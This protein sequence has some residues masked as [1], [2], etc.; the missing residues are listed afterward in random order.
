MKKTW[1]CNVRKPFGKDARA[2]R[3]DCTKEIH[4]NDPKFDEETN[5]I[6]KPKKYD[7]KSRV[8]HAT[9]IPP[10]RF[11]AGRAEGLWVKARAEP[12][13]G[14]KGQAKAKVIQN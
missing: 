4:E 6:A 8:Q 1:T 5:H 2:V 12:R 11:S 7:I 9:R 13:A 10:A 3:S 14:A